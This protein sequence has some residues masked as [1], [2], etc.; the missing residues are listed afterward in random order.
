MKSLISLV[1][2]LCCL[3]TTCSAK[4][5]FLDDPILL[6]PLASKTG[7]PERMMV[8]VP[9]GAVPVKHYN[10]TAKAIQAAADLNLWV[11]I[12]A[13]PA[14]L[15]D[16][17]D[18]VT[19]YGLYPLMF[20]VMD[21]LHKIGW[22]ATGDKSTEDVF[23]AGH[24]LGCAGA[25]GFIIEHDNYA[26][27]LCFGTQA[28][29]TDLNSPNAPLLM[30][31]GEL[32]GLSVTEFQPFYK[33]YLAMQ[34]TDG[35]LKALKERAVVIAPGLSH[36]DFCPGFDVPTDCY[37]ELTPAEALKDIGDVCAAWLELQVSDP[38]SA[39]AVAA[40][41]TLLGWTEKTNEFLEPFMKLSAM[42]ESSWCA[43][44]Q[45]LL[46]GIPSASTSSLI[47]SDTYIGTSLPQLEHCHT[48]F[49]VS[50]DGEK[51]A[52]KTCS[53]TSFSASWWKSLAGIKSA[54]ATSLGCKVVSA[55]RVA[56]QLKIKTNQNVTCKDVNMAAVAAA[57]KVALPRTL[58]RFEAKGMQLQL[59]DDEQT[60][61]NIGPLWV[62]KD[63]DFKV[64][65]K[66]GVA[67]I[68][69][70]SLFSSVESK[71]Y[72]GNRYCKLLS[73]AYV[74]QWMMTDSIPKRGDK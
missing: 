70:P 62:F 58:S 73:P 47:V 74:L 44:A 1:G 21:K 13:C 26:G 59:M 40:S 39:K 10:A 41:K 53:Q 52:V 29:S 31:S 17:Q 30:F 66:A 18:R 16:P 46:S 15:C 34:R 42:E 4:Q 67:K 25:R 51:L 69:S 5:P 49:S 22:N 2:V 54:A 6:P 38:K 56:Q 57:A 50:Q 11:G 60:L 65:K 36:S 68:A 14:N 43:G 35:D 23:I 28:N 32:D 72:P 55:D 24:S 12:V 71:I 48:N 7:L 27:L 20:K 3:A 33:N 8:F 37:S 61:G 9:G 45:Q 19:P 64:D 63:L